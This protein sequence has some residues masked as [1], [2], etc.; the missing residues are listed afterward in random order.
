MANTYSCLH[1]HVIFS[2]KNR[3]CWITPDIE[4]RLWTYLGGIAREHHMVP[5]K[6]RMSLRDT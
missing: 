4:L 1:Y 6:F 5:L 3:E 2:T